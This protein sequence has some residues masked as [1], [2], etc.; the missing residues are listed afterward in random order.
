MGKPYKI[1]DVPAKNTNETKPVT[2]PPKGKE[3]I[4]SQRNGDPL[5]P[6]STDVPDHPPIIPWPAA[7]PVDH[8]P[9]KNTK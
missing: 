8:K 3:I 1:T 9:F 2:S 7:N 4:R 6:S 5:P